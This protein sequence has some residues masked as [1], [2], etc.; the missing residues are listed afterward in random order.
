MNKDELAQWL[1]DYLHSN[2]QIRDAQGR[3]VGRAGT[4]V[5]HN[6]E[7]LAKRLQVYLNDLRKPLGGFETM[8]TALLEALK[9]TSE[10]LDRRAKHI[11]TV[12]A[13]AAWLEVYLGDLRKP[14]GGFGNM[15]E[16]LLAEMLHASAVCWCICHDEASVPEEAESIP[17][18]PPDVLVRPQGPVW[19]RVVIRETCPVCQGQS[20]PSKCGTCGGFGTIESAMPFDKLMEIY[21]AGVKDE[22][23][24]AI[25]RGEL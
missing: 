17:L 15:A 23:D 6:K 14:P 21:W 18:T 13:L 9:P 12:P 3:P 10:D 22:V 19:M 1:V 8:A 20:K 11:R 25:E 16:S 5:Q 2:F 4:D 7:D 24:A